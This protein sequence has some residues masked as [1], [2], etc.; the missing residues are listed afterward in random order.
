MLIRGILYFHTRGYLRYGLLQN[1]AVKLGRWAPPL[2]KLNCL[3]VHYSF[4]I[5][6]DT[7]CSS[8]TLLLPSNIHGVISQKTTI[9]I[10]DDSRNIMWKNK[11]FLERSTDDSSVNIHEFTKVIIRKAGLYILQMFLL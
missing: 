3:H 7:L 4:T 10:Y 6:V 9:W 1:D 8:E 2:L 11:C 5:K